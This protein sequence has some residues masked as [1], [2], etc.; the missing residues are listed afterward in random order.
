MIILAPAVGNMHGMVASM[1]EGK[2]KK[3]LDIVRIAQIKTATGSLMTLHGASG[4]DD[5]DLR[6]AIA[7]GINV[8]SPGNAESRPP[9]IC[10]LVRGSVAQWRDLRFLFRA[11]TQT[12]SR[13]G[14]WIEGV[15]KRRTVLSLSS[16]T[17][18]TGQKHGCRLPALFNFH[19]VPL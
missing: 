3:R 14:L 13:V 10:H 19:S 6:K 9:Q 18:I 1:I 5:E 2:T 12:L 4:T 17:N 16:A 15:S 8:A 11:F 7:A